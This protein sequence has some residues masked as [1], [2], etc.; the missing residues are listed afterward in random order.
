[1]QL[2]PREQF[3]VV[4][5]IEDHTDT[6]TYYV[7]AVIR[8]AKTDAIIQVSGN[9][10]LN[11]TDRGSQRFSANWLVPADASGQG[12]YVSILTSVYTDSGYTTKSQNYGDKID[13]YLIQDR[14]NANLGMGGGSDIDYKKIRKLIEE[15]VLEHKVEIQMPAM[16]VF[17]AIDI[18]T[19][20]MELSS[21]LRAKIDGINIP[22]LNIKPVMDKIDDMVSLVEEKHGENKNMEDE[23]TQKMMN[24]MT[25]MR[26]EINAEKE[27]M[28]ETKE[29]SKN[30][31]NNVKKITEKMDKLNII[32]MKMPEMKKEQPTLDPRITRLLKTNVWHST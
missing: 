8:N 15:V 6:A 21:E 14:L 12:F 7:R 23:N 20:L 16:P 24:Y 17:P 13:V 2:H 30:I 26:E 19:P 10:Y 29:I 22:K 4:R 3:T 25:S 28:A 32:E 1:M 11:L 5:Q 31:E 18:H 9:N 27:M